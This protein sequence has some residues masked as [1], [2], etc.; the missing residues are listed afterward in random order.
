[1]LMGLILRF[2]M[3]TIIKTDETD[4]LIYKIDYFQVITQM[5]TTDLQIPKSDVLTIELT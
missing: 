1:M 4:S 2:T 3:E 5:R